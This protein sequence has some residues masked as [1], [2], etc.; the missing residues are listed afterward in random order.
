MESIA[1][2]GRHFKI[3]LIE[4]VLVDAYFCPLTLSGL[5]NTP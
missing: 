3:I 5:L 1:A 4:K 2:D